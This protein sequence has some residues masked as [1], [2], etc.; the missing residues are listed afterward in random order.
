[1][2][3][4]TVED[5]IDELARMVKRGFNETATKR[6]VQ[7]G[8]QTVNEDMSLIRADIHDIKMV[9]GPLV[10]HVAAM[11]DRIVGLEKRVGRVERK[12]GLT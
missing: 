12:V 1:M 8:F 4:K 6:E 3:K 2:A 11:E 5:K 7:L 10:R 9:L